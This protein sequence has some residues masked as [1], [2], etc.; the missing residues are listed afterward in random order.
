MSFPF[1]PDS[2]QKV[3]IKL[4]SEFMTFGCQAEREDCA[5]RVVAVLLPQQQQKRSMGF[6]EDQLHHRLQVERICPLPVRCC[7][8]SLSSFL[9][10]G[11]N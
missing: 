6:C 7:Q 9:L 4:Q 10:P 5:V 1:N 11:L 2:L 3:M 8:L